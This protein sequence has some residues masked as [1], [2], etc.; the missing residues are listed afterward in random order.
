MAVSESPPTPNDMSGG[1]RTLPNIMIYRTLTVAIQILALA[2][3]ALPVAGEC[4]CGGLSSRSATVPDHTVDVECCCQSKSAN[5]SDSNLPTP[6][7]SPPTKAG[8]NCCGQ[9]TACRCRAASKACKCG[10]NCRCGQLDAPLPS[11]SAT[12][13]GLNPTNELVAHVT[14]FG[15]TCCR[16]SSLLSQ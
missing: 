8:D 4:G 10:D 13:P 1:Q 2:V 6:R 5:S 7:R 12:L 14:I 15:S 9:N 3:P 11:E 16:R